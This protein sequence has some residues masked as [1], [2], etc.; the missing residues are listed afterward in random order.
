MRANG[1]LAAFPERYECTRLP[2]GGLLRS[3]IEV[4]IGKEVKTPDDHDS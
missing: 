3:C 1:R 4:E 2:P